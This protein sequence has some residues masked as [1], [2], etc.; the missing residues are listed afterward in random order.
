MSYI[1]SQRL[2]SFIQVATQNHVLFFYVN[3]AFMS[4]SEGAFMMLLKD[5]GNLMPISDNEQQ[6]HGNSGLPVLHGY[7]R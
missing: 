2:H 1:F 6:R 4:A 5:F 3:D 7:N